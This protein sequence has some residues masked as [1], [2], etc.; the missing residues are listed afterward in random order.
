MKNLSPE[1]IV[2]D[3]ARI[4]RD[5][6]KRAETLRF[7]FDSPEASDCE[8]YLGIVTDFVEK[9]KEE[10]GWNPPDATSRAIV[11]V[12]FV[13]CAFARI[14]SCEFSSIDLCVDS[15]LE[16]GS[17]VGS[18]ASFA[19][20]TVAVVLHYF[21]AKSVRYSLSR[22]FGTFDVA[23][24]KLINDWAFEC[25]KISH[26]NPSGVDNS[27]CTYGSI[28]EFRKGSEPAFRSLR[29]GLRVCLVNTNVKR[30]TKTQ[31]QKVV[32][33]RNRHGDVVDKLMESCDSVALAALAVSTENA[34]L[35]R[36]IIL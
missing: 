28:V 17:G 31:V 9:Y 7:D 5:L 6:T 10:T 3:R 24:K 18:S 12:L 4:V 29:A 21:R 2:F 16:I 22:D 26:G 27:V 8:A 34:F 30:N 25:E 36:H 19:V 11:I 23:E 20:A 1:A 32:S 15:E 14:T 33:L 13:Y 35:K